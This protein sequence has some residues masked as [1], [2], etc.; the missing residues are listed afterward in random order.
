MRVS[1]TETG[2]FYPKITSSNLLPIRALVEAI[3]ANPRYLEAPECPYPADVK[4]FFARITARAAPPEVPASIFDGETDK[5]EVLERELATLIA[6]FKRFGQELPA[7]D[8]DKL[9]YFKTQASLLE[10]LTSLQERTLNLREMSEF[11]SILLG[12][13]DEI[14]T[15]DQRDDFKKRLRNHLGAK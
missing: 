15:V 5:V 13:M 10:K 11:Q 6:D 12:I 9:Q 14:L 3:A 1:T 7:G 8:A 4:E 2:M